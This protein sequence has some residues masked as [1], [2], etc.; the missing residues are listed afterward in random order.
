MNDQSR[1]GTADNPAYGYLLTNIE[2]ALR[3]LHSLRF[4]D[5]AVHDARKALKKARAALRLLQSGIPQSTYRAENQALRDAGRRLSQ[6]RDAKSLLGALASLRERYANRLD[7]STIAPLQKALRKDLRSA[8]NHLAHERGVRE[9]CIAL[10]I[11]ARRGAE[12]AKLANVHSTAVRSG[13]KRVYRKGRNAFRHAK[14]NATPEML[15]EWRKQV[16]YLLNAID[17]PLDLSNGTAQRIRK[18]ADRLA[19]RLGED[20]DLAA[21]AAQ[22]A[23]R[24]HFAQAAKLLQPLVRM[25]RKKLQKDAFKLGK[26]IYDGKPRARTERLLQE[27]SDGLRKSI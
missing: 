15:H 13:L 3:R 24:S 1:A 7:S 5:Q 27:L 19:D 22:A 25:R 8:R 9:E 10:L 14:K 23:H 4:T 26:K 20:H 18:G 6:V 11:R 16:K 12:Q 21:L 17:G 2:E